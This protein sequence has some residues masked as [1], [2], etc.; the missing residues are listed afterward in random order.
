MNPVFAL[1][2]KYV[3]DLP[4]SLRNQQLSHASVASPQIGEQPRRRSWCRWFGHAG[5][6]GPCATLVI[7]NEPHRECGLLPMPRVRVSAK[8][9]RC[10]RRG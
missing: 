7:V 10:R 1:G 8:V 2:L 5:T 3:L 4:L 6:V 9:D